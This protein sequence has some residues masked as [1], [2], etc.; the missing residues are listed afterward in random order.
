MCGTHRPTKPD[1]RRDRRRL[2]TWGR[3]RQFTGTE[4]LGTRRE[5]RPLPPLIGLREAGPDAT[6][7]HL[8]APTRA[9]FRQGDL[10]A[11]VTETE[12]NV[13]VVPAG[14]PAYQALLDPS[15]AVNVMLDGGLVGRLAEEAGGDRVEVV[16]GF[17]DRDPR[18]AGIVRAFLLELEGGALHAEALAQELA[19]HLLRYHCSLGW[20]ASRRL[21]LRENSGLSRME[22]A[23]AVDY[24]NDNLS[25]GFSLAE[26]A[27]E[28]GPSHTSG[29]SSRA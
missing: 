25:R 17:E 6:F 24:M 3:R 19:V 27:G 7:E 9:E 26:L 12:G 11:R 16:G 28:V 21:A 4:V 15:E 20:D 10:A 14:V 5:S 29:A 23:T 22:L 2:L 18:M 13:M 1:T 8:G